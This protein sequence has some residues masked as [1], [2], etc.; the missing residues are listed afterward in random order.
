MTCTWFLYYVCVTLPLDVKAIHASG[1][2]C[3][4][5]NGAIDCCTGFHLDMVKQMCIPCNVGYSGKNCDTKCVFPSF[6]KDCKSTCNCKDINCDHAE[7]CNNS[8]GKTLS[9]ICDGVNGKS[10]CFGFQ[11]D[12]VKQS[13]IP[14]EAGYTG[15]NCTIKCLYPLYGQGCQSTCKCT[16][17]DCNSLYGCINQAG[18]ICIGTNGIA[19]CQGYKWNNE[20]ARCIPCVK[21]FTG[22]NCNVICPFPAYGLDCQ[23]ICNCTEKS[24][25]PGDGCIG[26][27]TE[28]ETHMQNNSTSAVNWNNYQN[29]STDGK[30]PMLIIGIGVLAAVALFIVTVI[31]YTYRLENVNKETGSNIYFS[32]K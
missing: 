5:E 32:V 1:G 10:C 2:L 7:G 11:W 16:K 12:R 14:C 9:N 19:C 15:Y 8:T 6:G 29:V 13:C 3:G 4:I 23:S 22:H 24:C 28:N 17:E 31:F 20:E 26:H 25:D 18:N 27:T 30:Q 21:G